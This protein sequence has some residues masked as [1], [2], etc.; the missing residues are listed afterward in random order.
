MAANRTSPVERTLAEFRKRGIQSGIVERFI[1]GGRIA[2]RKDLFGFID[3][4]A[5]EPGRGIV[6]V[7][8]TGDDFAAH[9]KKIVQE[10]AQ[11]ACNWLAAGGKIDLWA[12]RKVRKPGTK[13]QM[14]WQPRIEEI[15][16]FDL[17][18]EVAPM[19]GPESANG[20]QLRVLTRPPQSAKM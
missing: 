19:I 4:I 14:I 10:K 7:Q 17:P 13:K 1:R 8:V 6:G 3:I 9:R 15:T 11:E 5:L 12:W 20:G 2:F 18:T 16:D